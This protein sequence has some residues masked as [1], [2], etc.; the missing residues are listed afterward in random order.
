VLGA[1]T[2]PHDYE[3]RPDDI[4]R[5]SR[6]S[7]VVTSGLGLDGWMEDVADRAGTDATTLV[8]GDDLP[9][10]V[11]DD[12]HWWHDPRNVV[13]AVERIRDALAEA[14]PE[15]AAA[16]ERNARAYAERVR[17]LD[18]ELL[19]CYARIPR[20]ARRLVTDHDAFAYLAR[21]YGLEVVGTVIPSSSTRAQ[22]SAGELA[23]LADTI[24][25]T[26]V[27]AIFPEEALNPRVTEA[28]AR[29]T[30]ASASRKLYGDALGE[31][32]TWL[33]MERHNADAIVAG[34]TGGQDGCR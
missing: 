34:L 30:G 18:R 28:V 33:E 11:A 26:D 1:N 6:A 31:G 23:A 4:A 13:A 22:P 14:D 12:P 24:R 5:A 25:A 19:A 32:G 3:P 17:A 15:G 10:L 29:Q 16:Y 8:L 9:V 20:D 2:D 21:R 27:R 7:V